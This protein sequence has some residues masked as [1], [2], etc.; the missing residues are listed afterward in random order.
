MFYPFVAPMA[1]KESDK[2]CKKIEAEQEI[3]VSAY[4]SIAH[5]YIQRSASRGGYQ[6]TAYCPHEIRENFITALCESGF[7]VEKIQN[8][9][10]RYLI[11]WARE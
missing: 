10:N 8:V 4:L 11:S 5:V 7:R 2:T 6:T 9:F 3:L 1:Q